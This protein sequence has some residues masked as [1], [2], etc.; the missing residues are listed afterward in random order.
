MGY[1]STNSRIHDHMVTYL[2][3]HTACKVQRAELCN[4][5]MKHVLKS[6]CIAITHEWYEYIHYSTG[7]QLGRSNVT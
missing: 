2:S 6:T 3:I 1:D 5:C 7:F 4:G